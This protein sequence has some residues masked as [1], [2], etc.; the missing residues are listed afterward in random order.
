MVDTTH[1]IVF[2]IFVVEG[3]DDI[4]HDALN[5]SRPARPTVP[6]EII[7]NQNIILNIISEGFI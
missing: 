7:N 4:F 2:S 3:H 1:L 5:E 6:L